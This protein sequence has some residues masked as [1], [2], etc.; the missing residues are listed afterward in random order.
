MKKSIIYLLF[1]SLFL[2]NC[3]NDCNKLC[4]TP[5]E[6]FQFEIVDAKT[7]INVFTNNT[8][9]S[10]YIKVVN[11]KDGS[12]V[13]YN[14]ISENNYNI[15]TINT[16]GWETEIVNYSIQIDNNEIFTLYVD[17]EFLSENCCSFS[18]YNEIKIEN[19]QYNYD[20]EKGL[21]TIFIN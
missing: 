11:L 1:I 19:A 14:F 7:G 12:R 16:I 6:P 13:D 21:Y 2:T 3:K 15:L 4:F 5:P 10:R 9:E 17:A 18:R 8:F 20:K